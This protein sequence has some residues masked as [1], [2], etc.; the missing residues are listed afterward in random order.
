MGSAV[1]SHMNLRCSYLDSSGKV[2]QVSK[3]LP[4]LG[5]GIAPHAVGKTS[6]ESAGDDEKR[7]IEIHLESDCGGKCIHV[8]KSNRI[9]EGVF[10][11]HPLRI[12][13]NEPLGAF[14][15]LIGQQD[16]RFLMAKI[17]NEELTEGAFSD[18]DRLFKYARG[19]KFSCDMIQSYDTP[20]RSWK[21][22]YFGKEAF[23]AT[24]QGNEG[25]A[26]GV[27]ACK[28]GVSGE[29]GVEDQLARQLAG[30]MFFE[31]IEKA[32]DFFG[33]L[34]LADIGI[35]VAENV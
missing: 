34:T 5:I 24:A 20:G 15:S 14:C 29:L 16:R 1:E 21:F 31:E 22:L 11:E 17:L 18:R 12:A 10:N 32:E 33:L 25:H 27:E 6:I 28:S 26:E 9:R 23:V 4:C 30:V 13:G 7:E 2:N 19:T 3:D 8:E 35:G